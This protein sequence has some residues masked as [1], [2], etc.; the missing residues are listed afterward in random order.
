M[1]LTRA[2][3]LQALLDLLPVG[4]GISKDPGSNMARLLDGLAALYLAAE[5][6]LVD[7]CAQWDPRQASSMLTDWERLLGLPD[8]CA[9]L[10]QELPDRQKTAFARL[11]ETGGQ[12]RAYFLDLASRLGEPNCTITEFRPLHCNATCNDAI[13]SEADAFV[14]RVHIPRPALNARWATCNSGCST[15]LQTY[16]PSLIEC[17]MGERK[18]A[19]THV[20]FAYAA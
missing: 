18:P 14:W 19:H 1:G 7:L 5:I 10:D 6:R 8:A 15:A 20:Q 9:P 16:E 12:S 11:T 4:M 2:A 17:V 3:W 13:Y